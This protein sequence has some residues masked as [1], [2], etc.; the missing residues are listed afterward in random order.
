MEAVV[1]LHRMKLST[2]FWGQA[3][4]RNL[5]SYM[6]YENRLPRGRTYLRQGQVYNLALEKGR[7]VSQVLGQRLYDVSISIQPLKS[8]RWRE[9]KS[10]CAGQIGSLIDLLAGRLGEGVM[11]LI[12]DKAD[13]LF[14][15]PREIRFDC[16]CPDW[17]DMCKHV[18]ATLY[19]VSCELD[20]KPELLFL[21][22]GV[23]H[24]EL[25]AEAG[26]ALTEPT[27]PPS[28]ELDG[29][30]LSA[31]FG[32]DLGHAAEAALQ[33]VGSTLPAPNARPRA[34][35]TAKKAARTASKRAT[36]QP[37]QKLQR[38]RSKKGG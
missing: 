18:A 25:V 8:M 7:I 5:E 35:K 6:D 21:L 24:A 9:L 2:T 3:W 4:N 28:A 16:N 10:R 14:P 20:H 31:L 29:A 22:R 17:A 36:A 12:T 19:A 33:A 38:K 15:G 1:P 27:A 37:T 13:G 11:A 34:P 32:I 30:D 23:D 26:S